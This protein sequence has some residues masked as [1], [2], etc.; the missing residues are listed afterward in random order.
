[1]ASSTSSTSPTS[2]TSSTSS[3]S[4]T[5]SKVTDAPV[6]PSVPTVLPT[7][8]SATSSSTPGPD[9]L[10]SNAPLVINLTSKSIQNKLTPEINE[11]YSDLG[12]TELKVKKIFNI[13]T[14][15]GNRNASRTM[16]QLKLPNKIWENGYLNVFNETKEWVPIYCSSGINSRYPGRW[17][18]YMGAINLR[19]ACFSSNPNSQAGRAGTLVEN[20]KRIFSYLGEP[21]GVSAQ[22]QNGMLD[23]AEYYT[24]L[25]KCS[26][27]Y[28]QIKPELE[29]QLIEIR[30]MS[31]VD[32]MN[33]ASS[34]STGKAEVA[35]T[36]SK[37]ANVTGRKIVKVRRKRSSGTASTSNSTKT[38]FGSSSSS[39]SS[40]SSNGNNP[41]AAFDMAPS[42][43]QSSKKRKNEPGKGADQHFKNL[44]VLKQRMIRIK[45][46]LFENKA[47]IK[48]RNPYNNLVR[49]GAPGYGA[50]E[51]G[52]LG[53]NFFVLINETLQKLF[54]IEENTFNLIGGEEPGSYKTELN[55]ALRNSL[56]ISSVRE[57]TTE[58]I[59]TVIGEDNIFGL[60][61][62]QEKVA[63]K[64]FS[65]RTEIQK[66]RQH[67]L[68]LEVKSGRVNMEDATKWINSV[69]EILTDAENIV[70]LKDLINQIIYNN[71]F[72]FKE[73]EYNEAI[74]YD[75]GEWYIGMEEHHQKCKRQ[76]T[77]KSGGRKKQKKRKTKRK[78]R[79][80]RRRTKK[81][82]RGYGGKFS[83][84]RRKTRRKKYKS[85]K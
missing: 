62:F 70:P 77:S 37:A 75:G 21:N 39:S 8:P 72:R 48:Y 69:I 73:V 33:D 74:E 36:F 76:K 54:K 43:L 57:K 80:K 65:M 24:W 44:I 60:P 2:P 19:H 34:P 12:I 15:D 14:N 32:S 29:R 79:R 26:G 58:K 31:D 67:I 35:G 42:T 17:H 52:Y 5:S 66:N 78:K 38:S 25:V 85:K 9:V 27:I 28:D 81:R 50:N 16:I 13:I 55:G 47:C 46:V 51:S 56:S 49:R 20:L 68:N 41:F 64:A 30:R 6:A 53:N 82:K 23:D 61:L 40:S 59:N 83:K 1:M 10:F 84:K 63:N 18:P 11:A 4:P 45:N 3:T 22:V 7:T 71:K